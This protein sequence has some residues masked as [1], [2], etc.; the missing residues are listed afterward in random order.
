[1]Q[2][3]NAACSRD[4][5][6]RRQ[7]WREGNAFPAG[8]QLVIC[9]TWSKVVVAACNPVHPSVR[10][11]S[12]V[13]FPRREKRRRWLPKYR[14]INL[15]CFKNT[16]YT[17]VSDETRQST[18]CGRRAQQQ[19]GTG[20]RVGASAASIPPVTMPWPHDILQKALTPRSEKPACHIS[21]TRV[22]DPV[23]RPSD[24]HNADKQDCDPLTLFV[25]RPSLTA[26]RYATNGSVGELVGR[27]AGLRERHRWR[28]TI[29]RRKDEK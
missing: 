14:G 17:H 2:A 7:V 25:I 21:K 29:V 24:A 11:K 12:R 16:L 15:H 13:G 28:V 19:R 3:Q 22:Q 1:M 5:Q 6:A 8:M 4:H 18:S 26:W 10:G 23:T 9:C 27:C 20:R